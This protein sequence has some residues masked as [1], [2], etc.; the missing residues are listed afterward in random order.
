MRREFLASSASPPMYVAVVLPGQQALGEP[1]KQSCFLWDG[2]RKGIVHDEIVS[3]QQTSVASRHL[4]RRPVI[5]SAAKDLASLPQRSKARA[6]DDSQDIPHVRSREAFSPNVCGA[7]RDSFRW[8]PDDRRY[9]SLLRILSRNFAHSVSGRPSWGESI[10]VVPGVLQHGVNL[11]PSQ[12]ARTPRL[13]RD[14][15][16]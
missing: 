12:I 5:L 8:Q 2:S 13:I 3:G 16:G 11:G 15:L 7:S 9:L 4:E 14:T 6:Q 1:E 10:L